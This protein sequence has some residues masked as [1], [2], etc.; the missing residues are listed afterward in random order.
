[1]QPGKPHCYCWAG[2]ERQ[3][4]RVGKNLKKGALSHEILVPDQR[5]AGQL[6]AGGG[7]LWERD[8]KRRWPEGL[9]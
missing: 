5:L 8:T 6:M 9:V 3:C 7:K 1:V 4:L 2:V